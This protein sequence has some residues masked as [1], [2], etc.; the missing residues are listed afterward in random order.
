MGFCR[1]KCL[2]STLIWARSGEGGWARGS[3]VPK[4]PRITGKFQAQ[5]GENWALSGYSSKPLF[6][7]KS[8]QQKFN[9][10]EH[11]LAITF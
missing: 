1:R 3:E 5:E 8:W 7:E 2:L 6:R 4:L 10:R 11:T 9:K